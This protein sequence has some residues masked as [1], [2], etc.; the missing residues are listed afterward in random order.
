MI[1]EMNNLKDAC[2]NKDKEKKDKDDKDKEDK[3]NLEESIHAISAEW[4]RQHEQILVEWADKAICY[5]W[6][7]SESHTNYSFKNT[8]FTVPVIIMSTLTGTANFAQERIP[9]DIQPIYSIIVGSINI[10]A[11]IITTIQQFL[12][13]SELNEA[14]RVSSISWDK[15]YR[16]V[17]LELSKS[18]IERMPAYQML[19]ISKE[20]YDRLMET[21]PSIDK[22]IISKFKTKFITNKDSQQFI[23]IYKPEIC[24]T[25][26]STKNF[27]YKE[28]LEEVEKRKTRNLVNIV[29]ENNEFRKKSMIVDTFIT[30]FNKEYKREPSIEEIQDNLDEKVSKDVINVVLKK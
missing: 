27:I 26:E 22:K 21:S 25:I 11:G 14:H 1:T 29:K 4:S 6:L 9:Q 24:D 17:K 19:K 13:I 2:K 20:E 18:R 3:S 16:N 7:H 10:L 30:N 5:R 15:F 28:T 12:K 23:D 8:W